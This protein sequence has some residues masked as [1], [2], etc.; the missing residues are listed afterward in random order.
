ML[1]TIISIS[2]IIGL[3]SNIIAKEIN[4]FQ[5]DELVLLPHPGKLIKSGKLE[6]TQEQKMRFV[7][8]IKSV[9]PAIFQA[10]MREAFSLEKKVQKAVINGKTEKELNDLLNQIAELKREAMDGRI[11]ALNHIQKILTEKQWEKLNKLSYE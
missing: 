11:A 1:K 5:I 3:S 10:K 8:E 2:L 6:L 7:K 9:Y 4:K